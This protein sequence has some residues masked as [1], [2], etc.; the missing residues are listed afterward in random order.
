MTAPQQCASK[1]HSPQIKICGITTP[2]DALACDNLGADAIGLVFYPKS[3]RFVKASKAARISSVLRPGIARVGVFVDAPFEEIIEKVNSCCLTAVQLHGRESPELIEKIMQAGVRVIKGLYINRPPGI[4]NALF[5]PAAAFLV[6]CAGGNL[7]GG[8]AIAWDW[9]AARPF[10]ETYPTILAGGLSPENAAAAVIA[11]CPDAVDV[12]SGVE[13]AP[14]RK[15]HVKIENFILA[16]RACT[17][18]RSPRRIF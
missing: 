5:Y 8:N 11:A 13:A 7:P 15:D 3:P 17:I 16:V 14:G 1:I 4:E 18:N 9:G 10:A 6:E 2:E 12:S